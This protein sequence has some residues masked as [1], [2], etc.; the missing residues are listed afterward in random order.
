MSKRS[1]A[2]AGGGAAAAAIAALGTGVVVERRV[3]QARRLGADEADSYG[4]LRSTPRRVRCS[5]GAVVHVEV[6]EPDADADPGAP[7]IVLVHGFA[8]NMDCWHFQRQALR[9]RHR[10]VLYDQRSHGRSPRADGNEDIDQLGKDLASVLAQVTS[11]PVVLVGHSMGGMS[12]IAFAQDHPRLFLD[13]VVGVGLVATTAGGLRPHRT[14][15]RLI[16]DGLGTRFAPAVVAVLSRAPELVDS[17]RRSGSNLGFLVAQRWAFGKGHKPEPA[18][19]EFLDEM[20]GETPY[21][22]LAAFFPAFGTLDR[23]EDIAVLHTVPTTIVCGTD[24]R[25]TPVTLSR[26]MASLVEGSRLVECRGS[27]H[28]VIFEEHELVTREIER[29]VDLA[30]AARQSAA[31]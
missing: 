5:D 10:V 7:T 22:V 27:G 30:V 12:V 3:V 26:K 25:L 19:V 23:F 1:W 15:S 31:G 8:L 2:W 18:L 11:G 24:D 4:T 29:L 21:D 20:L 14:L 6:D 9:G 13:R 17:A 16:P 28:M